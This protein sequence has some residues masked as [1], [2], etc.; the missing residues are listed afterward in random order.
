MSDRRSTTGIDLT[1][2]GWPDLNLRHLVMDINGTLSTEGVLLNGVAERIADLQPVLDCHL[3]S[4]DAFGTAGEIARQLGCALHLISGRDQAREKQSFV[5]NLV[6]ERVVA[7]GNGSNDELMLKRAQ[8][9]ICV[10]GQEGA[11]AAALAAADITFRQV[12]DALDSLLRP[13]RLIATLRR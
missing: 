4:G 11:S 10:V 2:P 1:I 13:M 12:D 6:A 3:I 5:T 9:G 8:L 7:V